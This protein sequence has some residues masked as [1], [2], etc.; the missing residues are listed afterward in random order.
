L[1]DRG[2]HL[3][4]WNSLGVSQGVDYEIQVMV[5]RQNDESAFTFRT[6]AS[7]SSDFVHTVRVDSDGVVS[8][9][10]GGEK[11]TVI[12]DTNI[13]PNVW[14]MITIASDVNRDSCKLKAQLVNKMPFSLIEFIANN[15][16]VNFD[17]VQIV[18][19]L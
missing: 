13:K 2:S 17:D 15:S 8:L 5:Y 1:L 11:P 16:T 4:G 3:L 6:K 12:S 18:E 19:K 10:S 7:N 9:D 14:T